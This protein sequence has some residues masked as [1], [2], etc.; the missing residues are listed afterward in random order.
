M[1]Q[2]WDHLP[3]SK[4]ID[5]IISSVRLYPDQWALSLDK[6][7][8]I[9]EKARRA[10]YDRVLSVGRLP[11]RALAFRAIA[12]ITQKPIWYIAAQAN[13]ALIA[14]DDCAYMIE[15][16]VGELEII[17]KFGDPRAILLLPA[18]IVYNNQRS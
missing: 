8:I 15:S 14:W 3:N 10:A 6:Q 17:A 2:T 16:E 4:Y 9:S 12:D 1:Q 5:W 13:L 18:C 11:E 7:T